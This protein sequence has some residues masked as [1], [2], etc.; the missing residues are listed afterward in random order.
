[1]STEAQAWWQTVA[2]PQVFTNLKIPAELAEPDKKKLGQILKERQFRFIT[3]IWEATPP[4]I[5]IPISTLMDKLA[6]NPD[7]LDE[8]IK[9]MDAIATKYWSEH[10]S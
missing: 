4:E 8:I 3:R 10:P 7:K 9:E 5:I 2:W 1:M 6:F